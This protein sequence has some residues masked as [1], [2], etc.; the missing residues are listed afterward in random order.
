MKKN[1][2]SIIR[3]FILFIALIWLTMWV[4][5][6]D[7]SVTEILNII[8]NIKI[9]YVIIGILCMSIYLLLEGINIRRT[10][11]TLGKKISIKSSFKYSLI[12]FFFSGITPAASGGQP[13]QI[14]YMNKDGIPVG[15]STVALL[16]NLTCM[17]IVTISM[18]IFSAIVNH[19]IMNKTLIIFFVIGIL[20]NMTALLLLIIAIFSRR[21]SRW[22]IILAI[23][24]LKLLKVRN[25]RSKKKKIIRELRKYQSSS[26]YIKNNRQL[27]F[28]NILTTTVQFILYYSIS[29]C[30]Y[31]AFGF[32]KNNAFEII[33]MQSL[34][35]AI[36]SGIP[37]P[38]AVGVSEGA[39]IE[40]YRNIYPEAVIKSATLLQ[41]CINFYLFVIISGIVVILFTIKTKESN[42]DDDSNKSEKNK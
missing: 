30:V 38:G 34:L 24:V 41:R 21:V 31:L 9:Q 2:K 19:K 18:G 37:S 6:K 4:I 3:N 23:K 8:K 22:M 1:S 33:T 11:G 40:I 15:H 20:L 16:I 7:Q 10:L 35:F 17:Q 32:S 27:I 28:K 36:V 26:A 14:Y 5:F 13:M 25:F 29:Y 12:G 42:T 39:F